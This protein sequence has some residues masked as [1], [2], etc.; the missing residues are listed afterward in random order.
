MR[1]PNLYQLIAGGFH[2]DWPDEHGSLFDVLNAHFATA[3]G[4]ERAAIAREVDLLLGSTDSEDALRS[5]IEGELYGY[6][7]PAVEG[8]SYREFLTK[9]RD[10]VDVGPR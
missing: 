3:T 2:Q 8:L 10:M 4:A 6:V 9:V 1:Y 5:V 7:R